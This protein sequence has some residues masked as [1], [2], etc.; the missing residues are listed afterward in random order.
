MPTL[1][2]RRPE[3]LLGYGRLRP[4][5]EEIVRDLAYAATVCV[6]MPM[7]AEIPL[8]PASRSA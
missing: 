7:A 4:R 8:L 1:N 2:F 5:Q 3:A 6:V